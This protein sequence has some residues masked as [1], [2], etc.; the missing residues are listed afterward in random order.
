MQS[1]GIN[2]VE[3][4]ECKGELTDHYDPSNKR[5]AL[6]AQNYRGHSLLLL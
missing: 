4:I 1:A 6:S 5:L 3:I 2:D